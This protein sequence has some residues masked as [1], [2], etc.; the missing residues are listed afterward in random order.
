MA[1]ERKKQEAVALPFPHQ[2]NRGGK[3]GGEGEKRKKKK[4]KVTAT[5][6]P[7]KVHKKRSSD[8]PAS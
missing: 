6:Y 3:K 7:W 8:S 5:K 1:A 4:G 2:K